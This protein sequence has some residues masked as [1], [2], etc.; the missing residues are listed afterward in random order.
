MGR[1]GMGGGSVVRG[2]GGEGVVGVRDRTVNGEMASSQVTL[3]YTLVYKL[4]Y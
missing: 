3:L 1:P 4:N 2:A